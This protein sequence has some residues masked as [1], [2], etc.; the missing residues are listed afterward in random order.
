M[1]L[2][3][4]K[5]LSRAAP[6]RVLLR[7]PESFELIREEGLPVEPVYE[8]RYRGLA[9]LRRLRADF[10]GRVRLV[11]GVPQVPARTVALVALAVGAPY[12]AGE[13][14]TR[15]RPLLSMA[16]EKTWTKSIFETQ[17]ELAEALGLPGRLEFPSIRVTAE[18]DEWARLTLAS[19]KADGAR[20]LVAVHCSASE[21]SK[22]WPA[23]CF[24]DVLARL[25]REHP[26]MGVVSFGSAADRKDAA[27][28]RRASRLTQ[29]GLTQWIEGAGAWTIR[30]TVALLRQ[31]DLLI[32]GDTGLMHMAAAVGTTTVSVF[33]ATSAQRLAPG[34]NGGLTASPTAACHPCYRDKYRP[35]SCIEL[36][37][38]KEVAALALKALNSRIVC[39]R[40]PACAAAGPPCVS[41][42]VCPAAP[43]RSESPIRSGVPTPAC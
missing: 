25:A 8:R 6:V 21:T 42:R 31:C 13:A 1:S 3:L 17:Q 9:G 7:S 10:R 34:Y 15:W 33:G 39:A 30:Q 41:A 5:A 38:A 28:A 18:E 35:C 11:L 4:L 14:T 26:G 36:I 12:R 27:E 22:R 2:P 32:S 29:S 43:A 19:G 16:V 20:P 37:P 23:A 24:G 40:R